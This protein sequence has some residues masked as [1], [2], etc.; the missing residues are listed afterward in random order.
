MC[1]DRWYIWVPN[2][3]TIPVVPLS[4]TN[5]EAPNTKTPSNA[6]MR[7]V[8]LLLIVVVFA[9]TNSQSFTTAETIF[10][11]MESS[12]NMDTVD[13]ESE[14]RMKPL[15]LGTATSFSKKEADVVKNLK[16]NP[17]LAKTL[18]SSPSLLKSFQNNPQVVKTV[19]SLQKNT[20][21][22]ERVET[23]AKSPSINNLK[24]ASRRNP[25]ALTERSVEKLGGA[26]SNLIMPIL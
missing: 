11:S 8:Y 18:S 19:Q 5:Q 13:A 22:M 26:V 24:I 20:A 9:V 21:L 12:L 2:E 14:E 16:E 7:Q 15:S 3:A 4:Q 10:T 23:L 25:S 1:S 17:A 6:A